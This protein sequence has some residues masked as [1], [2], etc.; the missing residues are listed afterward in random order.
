MIL[1]STSQKS[2]LSNEL[3]AC[4]DQIKELT[5]K[6]GAQN[7][8]VDF[9]GLF[10]SGNVCRCSAKWP[11]GT[12]NVTYLPLA[13]IFKLKQSNGDLKT[14]RSHSEDINGQVKFIFY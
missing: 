1:F 4:K 12:F 14:V 9:F 2:K 7:K 8:T 10:I 3:S 5:E 13:L 6:V 11:S